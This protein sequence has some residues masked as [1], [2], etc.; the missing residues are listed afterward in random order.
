MIYSC[1]QTE[2]LGLFLLYPLLV[3]TFVHIFFH[4]LS[5]TFF[6]LIILGILFVKILKK[7]DKQKKKYWR[8]H[9]LVL[10]QAEIKYLLIDRLIS[11]K[12]IEIGRAIFWTVT[13]IKKKNG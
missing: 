2:I 13:K 5:I 9:N 7:K 3:L 10:E 8:I 11:E 6:V 4:C 1:N 12:V